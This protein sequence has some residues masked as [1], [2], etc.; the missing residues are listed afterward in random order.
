MKTYHAYHLECKQAESKLQI[1][2]AQRTKFE[3]SISPEKL[4]RSKK[5]KLVVKEIQKRQCKFNEAKLKSVKACNDYLLCMEA[6]NSA[7]HKY[8]VDDL[9]DLIDVSTCCSTPM[10]VTSICLSVL[11]LEHK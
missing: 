11:C 7:I 2:E 8:F 9:S 6:A 5:Y 3:Q 1:V 4:E 10:P